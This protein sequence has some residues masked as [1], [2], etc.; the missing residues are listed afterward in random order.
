VRE[1]TVVMIGLD[2]CVGCTEGIHRLP[3][4]PL[5]TASTAM[6]RSYL[7]GNREVSTKRSCLGI[8][9]RWPNERGK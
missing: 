7:L 3:A 5:Y 1:R 9:P 4:H 8:T 6:L 2:M